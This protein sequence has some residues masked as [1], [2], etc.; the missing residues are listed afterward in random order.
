LIDRPA[1]A[2]ATA[3]LGAIEHVERGVPSLPE[4]RTVGEPGAGRQRP[5]SEPGRAPLRRPR[6]W[7]WTPRAGSTSCTSGHCRRGRDRC[8]PSSRPPPGNLAH[9]E[10][11]AHCMHPRRG[12]TAAARC[13]AISP[14]RPPPWPTSRTT[15]VRRGEI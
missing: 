15:K 4:L 11:Q 14:S 12:R 9:L 6:A 5:T 8:G 1:L 2:G 13:Q 7:P 10:T 3:R